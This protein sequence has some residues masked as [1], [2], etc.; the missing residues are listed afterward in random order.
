M[1]IVKTPF[2]TFNFYVNYINSSEESF[3][4]ISFV[5]KT[6]K[7]YAILMKES[8]GKWI[9]SNHLSLPSWIIG[10]QEQFDAMISR[11]ILTTYQQ[12]V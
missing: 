2:G 5:D 6:N 1:E 8:D 9:I 11:E 10:L 12:A 3:F 7:M 4:H